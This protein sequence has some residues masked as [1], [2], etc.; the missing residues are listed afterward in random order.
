M[1]TTKTS[2]KKPAVQPLPAAEV[3]SDERY[4]I[5]AQ[6]STPKGI[7][8]SVK[9]SYWPNISNLPEVVEGEIEQWSN[10][11]TKSLR[12]LWTEADGSKTYDTENLDVFVA[13]AHLRLQA[14]AGAKR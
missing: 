1:P 12:I 3:S 13:E 10:K 2:T 8:V 7:K 5:L 4:M 9:C 14:A 11:V 6:F